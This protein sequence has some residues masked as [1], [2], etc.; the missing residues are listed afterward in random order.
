MR[1]RTPPF[2]ALFILILSLGSNPARGTDTSTVRGRLP[3]AAGETIMLLGYTDLITCRETILA[4]TRVNEQDEFELT[5][6]TGDTRLV[7]LQ[8]GFY[9]GDLYIE[10][11]HTYHITSD[12]LDFADRFRPFYN[13]S[14]L[15]LRFT[16]GLNDSLNGLTDA[17]NTAYNTFLQANFDNL[18]KGRKK[19]LTDSLRHDLMG[20][21]GVASHDFTADFAA[22]K[23]ATLE[24]TLRTKARDR[25]FR[26]YLEDKSVLYNHP[27]YMAFFNDYFDHYLGLAG[28]VVSEKDLLM[29]I[30]ILASYPA[31]FDTLCKDTLLR[32][33]RLREVVM[34]KEL[35]RFY[36]VKGYSK[37]NILEILGQIIKVGRYPENRRLASGMFHLLTDLQPGYPLPDHTLVNLQGDSVTLHSLRGKPAYLSFIATWSIA[38]LAEMDYMNELYPK[39]KDKVQFVTI[40]LDPDF[41][42]L[43]KYAIEKGY[44]WLILYN[45]LDFDLVNLLNIKT[46]STFMLIDAD[47]N[48]LSNPA[49]KPDEGVE[50]LFQDALK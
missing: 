39:Y 40:S 17:I 41:G 6:N 15:D 38:C 13:Y 26:E 10:P 44:P 1:M 11:G 28:G 32:D 34:I 22:Y 20:I 49:P 5:V 14:Y 30:N 8:V 35:G 3:G 33:E 42:V 7:L 25:L 36:H 29:G 4:K 31:L 16:E 47:V 9:R 19:Y 23:I 50:G 46:F 21:P 12:S 18:T 2:I 24:L 48:I 45:G 43:K 27:E 37:P